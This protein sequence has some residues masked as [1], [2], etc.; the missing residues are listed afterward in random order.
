MNP[1]PIPALL[2]A[3]GLGTRL[4][5]LTEKIPKCL[6]PIHGMP[7]LGYWLDMLG[8]TGMKPLIV[9]THHHAD[10]VRD[11]IAGSPWRDRVLLVHE[12]KLLGTGGTLLANRG[13]LE[14]GPFFAAHADN[15]SR[16]S[17]RDFL[18]AHMQRPA[19][20]LLTMMLFRTPTPQ[21]CGIV[22]LDRNGVVTA[23][24]EKV[25]NPPGNLANGAVYVMEPEILTLLASVPGP[26]KDISL[27]L[28]P[29]CLGKMYTWVNDEYHRDIG[30]PESYAAAQKEF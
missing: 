3:A 10:T 17:V 24:H 1:A 21:S 28:L 14:G 6:V 19:G 9:N 23:F 27:D 29:R 22:E 30:T 2:L 8:K 5:P 13:H 7:L 12:D 4:A 15:L 11:F 20:C 18:A 25:R 16:F 26:Y